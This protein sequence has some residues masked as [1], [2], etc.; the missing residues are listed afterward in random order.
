MKI[1]SFVNDK[2]HKNIFSPFGV[3]A[4]RYLNSR[5]IDIS[6]IKYFKLGYCGGDIGYNAIKGHVDEEKILKSGLFY[7]KDNKIFDIF[8]GRI[9][10][11]AIEGENIIHLTSRALF[12]T[13]KPH[14]HQ[15]GKR[16]SVFNYNDL[17]NK[18]IV[19]TESPLDTI[20]LHQYGIPSISTYGVNGGI[21]NVLH[22]LNNK[23]VFIAYDYDPQITKMINWELIETGRAGQK[24]SLKLGSILYNSG[25]NSKIIQLPGNGHKMD[26]NLFFMK[27]SLY[28][29]RKLMDKAIIFSDTEYCK[30][31]S[32]KNQ[33]QKQYTR[34][35]VDIYDIAK[36][37]LEL[38][39]MNR[40]YKAVCPFHHD[41]KPSLILYTDTNTYYCFGIGCGLYG[42]AVDL[43][44]RLEN[45]RGNGLT[46][47]QAITEL[48]IRHKLH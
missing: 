20:T 30:Q 2:Y 22:L 28:D 23:E 16:K 47:K 19:I 40:G 46:R 27:Y 41:D 1:I 18:Y 7:K 36:D 37:Y 26:A 17:K 42:D 35:N 9:T 12:K 13:D 14:M 6:S 48:R 45:N 25:I 31:M 4:I 24:G 15:I 3:N 11:P 8:N 39:P 33:I 38:I 29:F 32:E 34:Y 43:F 21:K 44:M 5:G 10:I